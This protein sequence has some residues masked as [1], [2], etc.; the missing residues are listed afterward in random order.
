MACAVH[1]GC[2]FGRVSVK[3]DDLVPVLRLPPR[4][5]LPVNVHNVSVD[6][7]GVKRTNVLQLEAWDCN[8][9]QVG[10]TTTRPV[11]IDLASEPLA[12]GWPYHN[13]ASANRSSE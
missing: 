11:Q 4:E 3:L 13:Q 5:K 9:Q 7:N 12:A 10:L 2:R 6:E 8:L 1:N